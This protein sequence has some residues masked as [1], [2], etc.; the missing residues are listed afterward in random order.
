[1]EYQGR[2][3]FDSSMMVYFRKRVMLEMLEEVNKIL[4]SDKKDKTD[5][6]END[7]NGKEPKNKGKL[8]VDATCVP[9]DIKYPTDLN[10]LN[11]ARE[12]LEGMIDICYE[13]KEKPRTHRRV[14]R[15]DYLTAAK[16]KKLSKKG[17]ER[18]IR[19][20]LNY[21]K[22]DLG[23]LE[24]IDISSMIEI[25]WKG[26]ET[27]R[28]LYKQQKEMFEKDVHSVAHRIVSIS[29]PHIRPIVRGKAGADVEF[30]AKV[31]ISL[32]NGYAFTDRID[33]ENYNEGTI[34]QEQI[35]N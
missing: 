13:G 18:A 6:P 25:D 9:V 29:Q 15:K 2:K 3:P 27:I 16:N 4:F 26:L 24:K 35:E 21:V 32:V 33:W 19:K 28:I 12:K 22:R 11:E 17:R 20:Q 10:L 1:L 7:N 31:S 30:G 8:I 23:Y 14:A 34:L 5:E